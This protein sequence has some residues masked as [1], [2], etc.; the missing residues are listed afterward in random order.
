MNKRLSYQ[1]APVIKTELPGPVS[2]AMLEKQSQLETSTRIYTEYFPVAI[3]DA[4]GSTIKD[5]DGNILIDWFAGIC[6]LNLGHAHPAVLKAIREQIEKIVHINELPTEARIEFLE[7]LVS[8][9]PGELQNNARVMFTVTGADACEAAISLARF[10]TKKKT[11]IAFG[12]AYHG[13]HGAIV[14]ATGNIHYREYAGVPPYEIY[15]LPYPYTYRFPIKVKEE[16]VAKVVVDSLEYTLKD[17]YSG[18]GPVAGVLVEP[19]QGEGGY[20]VPPDDFLPMLREVTEKYSVPLIVD[21]IQTGVGRTGRIWA[22]ENYSITPDI[23]C[24]SKSIGGGIPVSMIAY[25]KEYDQNLPKA[26]HLGTY[27]ANPVALAAGRAVLEELKNSDLLEHVRA[28]GETL[29]KRFE[30][31]A[32]A[33]PEIGEVRGKGY[34]IGV[35]LVKDQNK[36]PAPELASAL[37][38]EMFQ[39]GVL[40]HTCGHY[41]NVM[42]FMAPLTIE[43]DLLDN[44][45][46]IFEQSLRRVTRKL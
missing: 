25:R 30:E 24:V 15:H 36:T 19:I 16:D 12:G 2:K 46:R 34:M 22:S 10:V 38:S 33:I 9:L 41:S 3:S 40:M 44:G 14:G 13:V 21:E 39:K 29:K 28:N 37:R 43:Q 23:M 42:R 27:R 20:I 1:E 31:I 8:T 45:L 6:V 11:I 35:E 18:V 17:P 26:F 4:R 5:M 32:M 7:T